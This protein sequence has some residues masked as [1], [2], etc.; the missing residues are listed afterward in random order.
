[1]GAHWKIMW[2]SSSSL[3]IRHS[4]GLLLV[5]V[6][7]YPVC[8][9]V[10]WRHHLYPGSLHTVC[11]VAKWILH[12]CAGSWREQHHQSAIVSPVYSYCLGV[13]DLHP[14]TPPWSIP[15]PLPT[16]YSPETAKRP[17]MDPVACHPSGFT[18]DFWACSCTWAI[19]SFFPNGF[20]Q[21]SGSTI[22]LVP[23][24]SA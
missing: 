19:H 4:Q 7:W 6:R 23:T 9:D 2:R 24:G 17:T 13:V 15:T 21:P 8:T 14:R 5:W 10:S 22:I 16:C 20:F 12:Y 3:A 18:V 11:T 1:M